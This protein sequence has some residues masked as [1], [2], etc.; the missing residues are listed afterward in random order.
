MSR[1]VTVIP[2]ELLRDKNLSWRAKGLFSYLLSLPTDQVVT[3]E[4][5]ADGAIGGKTATATAFR[6]LEVAG[7]VCRKRVGIGRGGLT[8]ASTGLRPTLESP[9]RFFPVAVSQKFETGAVYLLETEGRLKIGFTT[10]SVESRAKEISLAA[11]C[12][13]TVVGWFRGSMRDEADCLTMFDDLRLT[14]EWFRDDPTIRDHFKALIA[15]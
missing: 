6:E 15:R 7:Y 3:S 1:D 10:R 9:W 8:V 14:G 2:I 11:G 5:L 13:V 4:S 12:K